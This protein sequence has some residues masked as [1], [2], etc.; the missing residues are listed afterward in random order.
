MRYFGIEIIM[1]KE[2]YISSVEGLTFKNE[3]SFTVSATKIRN[4]RN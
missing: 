2:V 3:V 1:L 4:D